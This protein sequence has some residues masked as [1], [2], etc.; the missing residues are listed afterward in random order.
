LGLQ[1]LTFRLPGDLPPRTYSLTGR[2]VNR[3]TQAALP[4]AAGSADIPLGQVE[5]PLA[6]T[7]RNIDP[8]R[9]PNPLPAAPAVDDTGLQL[10]GYRLPAR[11]V[12]PGEAVSLSLHWQVVHQP[13]QAYRL[14]F[15]LVDEAGQV[16]YRWPAL[17]PL[18]GEWPTENWPSG[19]WVQDRPGLTMPTE[20][21]AGGYSL[22]VGWLP[23]GASPQASLPEGY[24]LGQISLETAD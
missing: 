3:Q 7:P 15:Y 9:L 12:A 6:A 16:A 14:H 19:Y 18:D 8:A 22:H 2:V 5:I 17:P 11:T 4:T 23:A 20:T 21:P 13:A 10:R 1:L 24:N